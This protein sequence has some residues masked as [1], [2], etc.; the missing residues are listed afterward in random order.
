MAMIARTARKVREQMGRFSGRLSAGLSKPARR[1][2]AEAV[3][4]MS[5]RQ[6]MR[7]TEMARAQEE[8]IALAKTETRLSRNAGREGL[9]LHLQRGL[10]REAA[11]QI[12]DDTLLVLDLSDLVKPYARRMEHLAMVRDGSRKELAKGY[13]LSHVVG[14]E[15][16]GAEIIPLYGDLHSTA[17]EDFVSENAHLIAILRTVSQATSGRGIWVIDRGGDRGELFRELVPACNGHR[18]VIRLRGDRYLLPGGRR[19]ASAWTLAAGCPL[20]FAT[21]VVREEEGKERP[22][23][24]HYG[25]REVRL[26][27]HPLVPLQL[28]VIRG[29]GSEPML[30]LTNMPVP[31]RR[32]AV[33]WVANAYVTRWKIEET[34][35]FGKQSYRLEDIRVLSYQRLKTMVSLMTAAMYFTAVILGATVKRSVLTY[36]IL[37][38]AK[39]LFGIPNFR[40]YA[41]SDGIRELFT[42]F[43]LP[44]T[45]FRGPDP[46]LK[47]S[48]LFDL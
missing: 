1:F 24:L 45:P 26:P 4:G 35:R 9:H 33:W 2:V 25:C 43:P 12:K 48:L 27:D 17:A 40:Y 34:I 30:L 29:W 21:T 16:G 5:A 32:E 18:F 10:L 8:G 36:H 22:I 14:V 15:V 20:P 6:S 38:A 46:P 37:G 31:R 42:R 41:L 44:V 19:G 3:Y 13:W 11:P 28:V 47:Q 39:R 7:L 23:H